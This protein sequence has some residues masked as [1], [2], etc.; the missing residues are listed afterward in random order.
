MAIVLFSL[1]ALAA[2]H[3]TASLPPAESN[4]GLMKSASL[5]IGTLSK[6][7]ASVLR[8]YPGPDGLVGVIIKNPSGSMKVVWMTPHGAAIVP[9]PVITA[10]GQDLTGIAQQAVDAVSKTVKTAPSGLPGGIGESPGDLQQN[11]VTSPTTAQGKKMSDDDF[12]LMS[13][14]LKSIALGTGKREVWIYFDP[15]CI[16]CNRLWEEMKPYSGQITAHWIPVGFLKKDDSLKK[17]TGILQAHNPLLSLRENED[18]F[19]TGTEEGGYPNP[20]KINVAVERAVATNTIGLGQA[21]G[22]LATPTVVY[23]GT[24]GKSHSVMGMP[25][26]LRTFLGGVKK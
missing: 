14:H 20:S 10:A 22:E 6:N 16:F 25:E 18:R 4:A 13:R 1:A 5:L 11:P 26:D 24:D 7:Q 19:D 3:K 8:L 17:A 21:T 15:N 23:R 2:C 9:G 12:L